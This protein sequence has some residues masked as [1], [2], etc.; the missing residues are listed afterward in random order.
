MKRCRCCFEIKPK[1]QFYANTTSKDGLRGKCKA[2]MSADSAAYQQDPENKVSLRTRGTSRMARWRSKPE[3]LVKQRKLEALR[4]AS[5]PRYALNLALHN[6]KKRSIVEISVNQMIEMWVAQRGLCALSGVRMTWG[7]KQITG[8]SMSMDRIDQNK[9]YTIDNVRLV[10][11]AVNSLRGRMSDD[12]MYE[13]AA[14]IVAYRPTPGPCWN[15]FHAFY[16]HAL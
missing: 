1:D 2:C 7:N 5:T 10:C 15:N 4:R 6:A 3:N 13:M 8:T 9:E 11:H 12:Q 16:E 14:A